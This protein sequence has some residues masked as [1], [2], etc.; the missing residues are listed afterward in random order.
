MAQGEQLG[1]ALLV[2]EETSRAVL[3]TSPKKRGKS[4]A[5]YKATK[6]PYSLSQLILQAVESCAGRKG[7][8]LPALKKQLTEAG[9]NLRRNSRRLKREL[10]TLVSH[11]LLTRVAGTTGASESFK[12]KKAGKSEPG[13]KTKA[14][15]AA[16]KSPKVNREPPKKKAQKKQAPAN[17]PRNL[18]RRSTANSGKKNPLNSHPA[19]S[20]R[21]APVKRTRRK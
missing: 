20:N 3:S 1:D 14:A 17:K 12:A 9:Y 13:K 8:S 4:S 2:E 15:A 7:L 18:H 16:K 5:S 11:G 19:G 21:S 10:N 6:L